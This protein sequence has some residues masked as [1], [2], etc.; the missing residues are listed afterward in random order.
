MWSWTGIA[1]AVCSLASVTAVTLA[2]TSG[3]AGTPP[4]G[5]PPVD[6]PAAA[7]P[8]GEARSDTT[9]PASRTLETLRLV[10]PGE[11]H[12]L[13]GLR[14]TLDPGHNGGNASHPQ[15]INR[16]VP[17]GRG[18]RKACN[19]V[20][21]RTLGGYPEHALTWRL[22]V[23]LRHLLRDRGAHVSLTRRSDRGVGPCVNVRGHWP[24]RHRA[25]V[26]LSIH[27]NGSTDRS[28]RGFHVIRSWPPL[29]RSQR[30]GSRTLAYAVRNTLRDRGFPT[31]PY[32]EHGIDKRADLAGLNFARRP[33]VMVEI[34]EMR[35][36][37]DAALLT[38]PQGRDRYARAL[39]E[40]L[41]RWASRH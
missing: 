33:T 41:R 10:R 2:V 20:G 12:P 27:A 35:N 11:R 5:T 40:A 37:R 6:D 18:G 32:G 8:S 1:G 26:A 17:D 36:R 22:A 19:T 34:A 28:I 38:S 15:Q 25:D 13:R 31:S 30:D 9:H 14:V 16:Q 3:P 39:L 7:D 4:T 24:Q 23:R 29:S 21:T